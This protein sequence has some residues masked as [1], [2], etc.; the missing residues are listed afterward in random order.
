[1]NLESGFSSSAQPVSVSPAETSKQP[2][3]RAYFWGFGLG[4]LACDW[5]SKWI[6]AHTLQPYQSLQLI[7]EYVQ[8]TY[9]RNPGGAFSLLAYSQG[10]W[11]PLLFI[12]I[13]LVTVIVLSVLAFREK[14][15]GIAFLIPLGLI[16][17]GAAGNLVDRVTVGTVV[18]FIDVGVKA[19]R[20]PVF[21]LA[22][23]SIDIGV[24]W[25]LIVNLLLK[26][27]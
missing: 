9:V 22:D 25:F 23:S 19:Y 13:A 1:M 21:N 15:A 16:C 5:A 11:R 14:E 17:G 12:G 10:A 18:D 8:L 6:V 2:V 20:W 27:K 3:S 26:R 4:V 7:G 24:A